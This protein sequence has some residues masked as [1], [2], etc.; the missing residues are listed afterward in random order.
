[1]NRRTRVTAVFGGVALLA[2]SALAAEAAPPPVPPVAASAQRVVDVWS[3]STGLPQNYVFTILQTREGYLWVGTRGGL[4]RFDGVRFVSFDDRR[5]NALHDSEV[6]ALAEDGE[7]ALWIGTYGGGVSRLKDDAFTTYRVADGLPSDSVTA[8]AVGP[9][10]ELWIGTT[11]GL[12]CRRNGRILSYP[13][14]KDLPGGAVRALHADRHGTV[15]IGTEKG[16]ASYSS[17]RF[18]SLTAAYPSELSGLVATIDG[19]GEDGLWLTLW[20]AGAQDNGAR[21]LKDGRVQSFGGRQGV[22]SNTPTALAV[23]ADGTAW[24]G[25]LNGLCRMRDGR[26]ED[27][28]ADVSSLADRLTLQTVAARGVSALGVD[29][30]G[31]LWLGTRYDGLA[32]L[33]ATTGRL[34]TGGGPSEPDA[35]VRAL[36]ADPDGSV[37]L[38]TATDIRRLR[39]STSEVHVLE[40]GLAAAGIARTADG[41]LVVGTT[42]GL[43]ELSGGRARRARVRGAEAVDVSVVFTD[44][45]GTTWLGSRAAGLFRVAAER[46]EPYGEAVGLPGRQVRALGEDSRGGLWVGTR[47][48]GVSVLR[49]GRALSFGRA[50][51]L[52]SDAVQALCVDGEDDVWVATRQG[53]GRI[54][55]GRVAALTARHGL[56]GNFFYQVFDDGDSLWLT[57]ARG[58]ARVSKAELREAAEGRRAAVAPELLGA[59][60]GMRSTSLS[61]AHQPTVVRA[62]DGRLWFATARGAVVIDP[63]TS[64]QDPAPPAARVEEITVD[65]RAFAAGPPVDAPPGRGEIEVRYTGLSLRSPESIRF[66]YRLDGFDPGWIDAGPRRAV[67]YTNIPPG[68]YRFRVSTARGRGRWS[69]TEAVVPITIGPHF[70]E[71]RWWTALVAASAGALV[72]VGYRYRVRALRRRTHELRHRVDEAVASLKVLRGLLPICSSCKRIRSDEGYWHQIEEYVREHTEADFTHGICPEC[73]RELF[74]ATAARVLARRRADGGGSE[75]PGKTGGS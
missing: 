16:L 31:N 58:I 41:T 22:P 44:R 20:R 39:G 6:W 2:A 45:K 66:R 51:G 63:R 32:R 25:T 24:I 49:D 48:R 29:R 75:P 15:W 56:P 40:P 36:L 74:P 13:G 9:D 8:L 68:K 38:A 28:L 23:E 73:M 70:Y 55:D 42:T 11:A 30:E 60:S 17:G 10:D 53:L 62:A 27:P 43:F 59:E 65:G 50:Q 46:L 35:D 18:S 64:R 4:G 37:W 12:A 14:E 21:L 54:H 7:G 72:W 1:M 33:Q 3:E 61:V 71:T 69:E 67:R 34:V 52:P 5:P 26:C 19:D 57:Y 47:D